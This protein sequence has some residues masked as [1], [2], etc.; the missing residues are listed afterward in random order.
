MLVRHLMITFLTVS[1]C[2]W[3]E[4]FPDA[5]DLP[6]HQLALLNAFSGAS[7]L[8]R[9]TGVNDPYL[10]LFAGARQE[11]ASMGRALLERFFTQERIS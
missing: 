11:Q 4:D 9:L 6:R 5:P 2:P 3:R 10:R 8:R 1:V 7:L